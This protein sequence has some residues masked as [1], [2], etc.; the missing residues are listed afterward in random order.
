MK[1]QSLAAFLSGGACLVGAHRLLLIPEAAIEPQQV[2]GGDDDLDAPRVNR[3]GE[4]IPGL[5]HPGRKPTSLS[6][7]A[8]SGCPPIG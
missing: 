3:L 1:S 5:R 2:M 8:H 4:G 7:W 6:Q